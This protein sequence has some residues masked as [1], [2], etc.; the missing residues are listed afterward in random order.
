MSGLVVKLFTDVGADVALHNI[1]I[2]HHIPQR[3]ATAGMLKVCQ[4]IIEVN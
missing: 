2:V 4:K 3:N 1:E